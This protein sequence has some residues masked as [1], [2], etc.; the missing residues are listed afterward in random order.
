MAD[1]WKIRL[2]GM[3]LTIL[4]MF[5]HEAGAVILVDNGNPEANTTAP[6]GALAGS[7]WQF[8]GN[9]GLFTGMPVASDFFLTAK[10]VGGAPG[11]PFTLGGKSYPALQVFDDPSSDLKLVR[12]LGRF[13]DF[14]MLYAGSAEKGASAMVFGRGTQRGEPVG[15]VPDL[16]QGWLWGPSDARL[17][18]GQN[19]IAGIHTEGTPAIEYLQGYFSNNRPGVNNA[20]LSS[21]DSGGA[22]FILDGG[23]WKLAGVNSAVDGPYN[24]GTNGPGFFAALFDTRGFYTL[25]ENTNWVAVPN[26]PFARGSAF[27]A[28]RVSSRIDWINGIVT[29]T[30]PSD[31]FPVLESSAMP[32]GGFLAEPAQSHSDDLLTI[33]IPLPANR[34]F[35]RLKSCAPLK[36]AAPI[37]TNGAMQFSIGAAYQP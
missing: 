32:N 10:H 23:N 24:T 21:G 35:Y 8:V 2:C 33:S 28:T 12:V 36:L 15:S 27:Y 19:S 31:C 26:G 16:I 37:V 7:G 18:W 29:Q 9:W 13:P 4:F 30:L 34:R 14:A 11:Q 20:M 1:N 3:A 5:S 22:V 6:G 25:D 17:R